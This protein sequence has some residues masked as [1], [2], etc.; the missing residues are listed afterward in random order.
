MQNKNQ[1]SLMHNVQN[2]YNQC[3]IENI[4]NIVSS[5]KM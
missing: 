4:I 1:P 3:H 5:K 2:K